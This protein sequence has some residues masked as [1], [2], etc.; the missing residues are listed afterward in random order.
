VTLSGNGGDSP[1]SGAVSVASRIAN[2]L[3]AK[4]IAGELVP[5]QR[6]PQERVPDVMGVSRSALREAFQILIRERLLVH[7]MSRGMFVRR[8]SLKDVSDLY[9]VRRIVEC[10][11]V[12]EIEAVQPAKL[13]RLADAI[14][15]GYTAIDD[16][17]RHGMAQ[18]SIRF[19]SALVSLAGNERLDDIM[20]GILA[21]H[22]LAY[23]HLPN[24][25]DFYMSFLKR[26]VDIAAAVQVGDLG[27]AESLL[28]EYLADS[29]R[30]L[31]DLMQAQGAPE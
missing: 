5:G 9:Q 7:E 20:A 3:R 19:H 18:A 23:A 24:T 4:I 14:D 13:R 16:Q 26:H 10:A 15:A 12:R 30:D 11:A 1:A 22:R 2:D 27:E 21:E 8:L 25:T 29:E 28:R 31:L 6:V 17:D